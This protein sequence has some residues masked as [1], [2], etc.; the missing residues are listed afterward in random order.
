MIVRVNV[1]SSPILSVAS[2]PADL[3]SLLDYSSNPTSMAIVLGYRL[4]TTIAQACS[5]AMSVNIYIQA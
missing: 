4:Y 1:P 2:P 5:P 3:R